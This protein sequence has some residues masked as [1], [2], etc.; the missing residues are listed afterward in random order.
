MS[1]HDQEA[2][3]YYEL[4]D[5]C[6]QAHEY[7]KA[8][9]YAQ[10]GVSLIK[11][12]DRS[13]QLYYDLRLTE[14][15]SLI[16]IG[17]FES[18][19]SVIWSVRDLNIPESYHAKLHYNEMY[20]HLCL[21]KHH[22]AL[23]SAEKLLSIIVDLENVDEL[24]LYVRYTIAELHARLGSYE[25]A[26]Q[27]YSELLTEFE[28]N[29]DSENYLYC[30][31]EIYNNLLGVWYSSLMTKALSAVIEDLQSNGIVNEQYCFVLMESG[32]N[33]Q[34]LGDFNAAYDSYKK[35]LDTYR[36]L[37]EKQYHQHYCLEGEILQ[38]LAGTVSRLNRFDEAD[39]YLKEAEV[40][41]RN[42]SEELYEQERLN[43]LLERAVHMIDEGNHY[44]EAYQIYMT[45]FDSIDES[46]VNPEWL[47]TLYYNFGHIL[48]RISLDEALEAYYKSMSLLGANDDN[49]GVRYAK[50]L[51]RIAS[52]LNKRDERVMA[53]Q[54]FESAINI[55]RK[56]SEATNFS[57]VVTLTNAA[58]C[59]LDI[60][61]LG[62]AISWAEESRR[63]QN[64]TSVGNINFT[65]WEILLDAYRMVHNYQA[66]NTIYEE[67]RQISYN[68][69]YNLDFA[70]REV[71][72]LCSIGRIEE[73]EEYIDDLDSRLPEIE[74]RD[75]I[76]IET[77]IARYD[78]YRFDICMD[79]WMTGDN[80]WAA[81]YLGNYLLDCEEYGSAHTLYKSA[82]DA[83][84]TDPYYLAKSFFAST[85]C[86]D[87]E[88]CEHLVDDIVHTFRNQYKSVLGMSYPEKEAY[89]SKMTYLKN[90]VGAFRDD[91]DV[92]EALYDIS[93]IYK[94]FL[95]NSDI[96]FFRTLEETSDVEIKA[97][98]KELQLT[99]EL[100]ASE[101]HS[102]DKDSLQARELHINRELILMLD[103]LN[104]F[105][106]APHLCCD[107]IAKALGP[108]EVAIEI[109][110]YSVIRGTY[111]VA[112]I[113]RKDW[114]KP[115]LVELGEETQ[116]KEA[117]KTAIPK[118][119][120]PELPCSTEL[121]DLIWEPISRYLKPSDVVYISPSGILNTIALEA[122]SADDQIYVSDKY[123]IIR[124]SSTANIFNKD[125]EYAYDKSTIFGGVLYDS[126][127][128]SEYASSSATWDTGYLL[129]RSV[130]EEISYL[131][132]TKTEAENIAGLLAANKTSVSLHIGTDA[133]EYVFKSLS[134]GDNKIIHIA[135]HGFYIPQE[136]LNSYQYYS[137]NTSTLAM[138]RSGLMLAGAN[139]AW[140]GKLTPGAEDGI[141][142]AREIAELDLSKTELVVLSACETGLGE[143]TDDGI[144]GLQRA[145]KSAGVQTLVMS[146]WKV[147]DRAT[148]LLME[149]FYRFLLKGYSKDTAFE[150]AKQ[151]LRNKKGYDSPYYWAGF[152]MLD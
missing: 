61:E 133:N 124:V 142:T 82:F 51:N 134:R 71:E 91:V 104:D 87:L 88:Y 1:K 78:H 97:K 90:M 132:A 22:D 109:A 113:L 27:I 8:I 116:Y 12:I 16:S 126:D 58:N 79:S 75:Y 111:Y 21:D 42:H 110:D 55:F 98:V 18:A 151:T 139:D 125:L 136:K 36:S 141:L 101:S 41:I 32:T 4:A 7:E 64:S 89:W 48:E 143:I 38:S 24:I 57:Y 23:I 105:E 84:K 137:E 127:V 120:N 9:V 122:L 47:S 86:D 96:N 123:K 100:L 56:Q 11:K 31:K 69:L 115:V 72:R 68:G 81:Y 15:L 66:Y 107:S 85:V 33:A 19:L 106:F 74:V 44:E 95:I 34:M 93:L 65:T 149:S 148:N 77:Y 119:Y 30:C 118:L 73:A 43:L 62:R 63:V 138:E 52:I 129:D 92:N 13:V 147:N 117:L 20:C 67:Y 39:A 131:P 59:A 70:K 150:L 121:Y 140:N 54:Y 40:V 103:D 46:E 17:D 45:V 37:T 28:M 130:Y 145:F 50:I 108:G 99:K 102:F 112:M 76:D 3:T 60:G 144:E 94:N 10:N 80:A 2:Y 49:G 6:Y 35:A 5:S 25:I 29:E 135:T 26:N 152:I 53:I 14:V 128:N 146:L 114:E 83:Y